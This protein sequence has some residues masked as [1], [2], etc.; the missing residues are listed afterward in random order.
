MHLIIEA[1]LQ[2]SNDGWQGYDRR[3]RKIAA[4]SSNMEWARVDTTLWNLA[5]GKSHTANTASAFTTVM[6]T[7]NGPLNPLLP[8]CPHLPR[9]DPP[10][11]HCSHRPKAD[12]YAWNGIILPHPT[13]HSQL[14]NTIIFCCIC[15]K[16]QTQQIWATKPYTVCIGMTLIPTICDYKATKL[17]VNNF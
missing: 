10:H 2:Y 17:P 3:F 9:A 15:A 13:A 11:N 5:M 12:V 6:Q 16:Y 8:G 1:S 14:A 4:S 7:A